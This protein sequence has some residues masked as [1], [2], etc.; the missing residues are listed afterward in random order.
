MKRSPT[1]PVIKEKDMMSSHQA[2][3]KE[4]VRRL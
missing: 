4:T 1:L 2:K 3:G